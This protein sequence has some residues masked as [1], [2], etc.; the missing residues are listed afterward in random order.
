MIVLSTLRFFLLRFD[1]SFVLSF[2]YLNLFS[3]QFFFSGD[4]PF[5]VGMVHRAEE[6]SQMQLVEREEMDEDDDLFEAIDKCKISNSFPLSD[7]VS[8]IICF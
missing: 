2:L 6:A 1:F 8:V 5:G 7:I 3:F 4:L